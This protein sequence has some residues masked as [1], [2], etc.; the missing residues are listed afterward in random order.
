MASSWVMVRIWNA[1]NDEH[2]L[3]WPDTISGDQRGKRWTC[4]TNLFSKPK[5]VPYGPLGL[6]VYCSLTLQMAFHVILTYLFS[7]TVIK[8]FLWVWKNATQQCDVKW[9]IFYYCHHNIYNGV[10]VTRYPICQ[11][12]TMLYS[13]FNPVIQF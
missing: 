6:L 11:T 2:W 5:C 1:G 7:W 12:Y 13:R 8:L 9:P 4:S 10:G 3:D